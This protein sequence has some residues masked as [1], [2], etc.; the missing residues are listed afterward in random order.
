MVMKK[1]NLLMALLA[2]SLGLMANP[3]DVETAK[4]LGTKYMTANHRSAAALTLAHV[5]KTTDGLNA[6]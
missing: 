5:E 3:V 2:F 1:L 4:Q 6:C